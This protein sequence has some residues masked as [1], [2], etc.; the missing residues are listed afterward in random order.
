MAEKQI[1]INA[2]SGGAVMERINREL[3]DVFA[4]IVDP[5]TDAKKVRTLTITLKLK[6]DAKREITDVAI[7]TKSALAPARDIETKLVMDRNREGKVVAAELKSGIKN[8]MMV[9][10]DG[11]VADDQGR[12]VVGFNGFNRTQGGN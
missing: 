12:K 3:S 10:N 8:Q 5:N 2:L 4:N 7:Q 11:D 1:D 9:D 6:P